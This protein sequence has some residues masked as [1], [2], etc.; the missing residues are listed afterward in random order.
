MFG[1]IH[2][3]ANGRTA[4]G[5]LDGREGRERVCESGKTVM[6][7]VAKTF[8]YKLRQRWHYGVFLGRALGSD[9]NF[10]GVK[11]GEVV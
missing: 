8:R 7:F 9:Q 11:S 6:C 4:Y 2:L 10:V 3:G 5:L 1:K